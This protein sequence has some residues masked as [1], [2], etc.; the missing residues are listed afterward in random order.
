MLTTAAPAVLAFVLGLRHGLDADHLA[1]IDGLTRWN[2]IRKRPFATYCGSLFA[3]GH[4]AVILAAAVLLSALA[5]EWRP[6][7][8]LESTGAL[9]SAGSLLVLSI[10][11]LGVASGRSRA[12]ATGTSFGW[13]SALFA[14]LLRAPRSW[15][16]LLVGALFALSFDAITLAGLF[17]ASAPHGSPIDAAG[18]A[19]LFALGMATVGTVNGF[20]IARLSRHSDAAS[21]HA[22]R[23]MTYVVAAIGLLVASGVLL[24]LTVPAA[25][26]WMADHELALSLSVITT[27]FAAYFAALVLGR[28]SHPAHDQTSSAPEK[29]SCAD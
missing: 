11:N 16:V 28:R 14:K 27:V 18:L 3:T 7:E 17:A 2:V 23:A 21:G 10:V 8:F 25:Q 26:P 22:S 9:L 15:Q 4:A 1:A 5:S 20:W 13:R 19:L 12:G 24:T 29:L 6:P